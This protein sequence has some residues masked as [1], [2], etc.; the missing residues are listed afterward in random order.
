MIFWFLISK[1]DEIIRF[2]QRAIGPEPGDVY[3]LASKMH[4]YEWC[5]Y[6]ALDGQ[7]GYS[8]WSN[9]I[10]TLS[11]YICVT[12]SDVSGNDWSEM[13]YLVDR[14]TVMNGAACVRDGLTGAYYGGSGAMFYPTMD[15]C[16]SPIPCLA[17]S[18]WGDYPVMWVNELTSGNTIWSS[19]DPSLSFQVPQFIPNIT[20]PSTPYPEILT[21]QGANLTLIRGDDGY[22]QDTYV[23]PTTIK[24]VDSY[25]DGSLWRAAVTTA[26]SLHC[27]YLTFVS[28]TIEPSVLLP[29]S[30]GADMCL[31][32]SDL[33]PTPLIAIAMTGSGPGVCMINTSWP[34]GISGETSSSVPI[35]PVVILLSVPGIGHIDIVGGS[36]ADIAILDITGRII[37]R[38]SINCD[39]YISVSLTPGI[40]FLVDQNSGLLLH[41]AAVVSE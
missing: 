10:S 34:V 11:S 3:V 40:Y 29:N 13:G 7:T 22:F 1:Q 19:D 32:E 16:D 33:Y 24:S 23:F 25:L 31:L 27:P 20:G 5:E 38:I 12:D 26:I 2:V 35:V 14:A 4:P 8:A 39:E 21:R 6:F 28:P 37:K 15:I 36:Q 18:N 30:G 9:T 41:R 17:V